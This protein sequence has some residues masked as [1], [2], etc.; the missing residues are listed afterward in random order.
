ML[1]DAE[2]VKKLQK[3]IDPHPG[4]P[5]KGI[6]PGFWHDQADRLGMP[7]DCPVVPLGVSGDRCWLLDSIGQVRFFDPPYG[8]GNMLGLFGGRIEYLTWAWPRWGK[9]KVINGFANEE[10][11]ATLIKACTL[12]GPWEPQDSERWQG[13]WTDAGGNL[14]VHTGDKVIQCD[15]KGGGQ[16]MAPG[17]QDGFVYPARTKI[18][19]PTSL[20]D[21]PP[22]NGAVVMRTELRKWN[23]VRPEID[24]HLLLGWIGGAFLGGAL[25]WRPMAFLT[26]DKATGKSTLQNMLKGLFGDWLVSAADTTAA[27]IYQRIGLSCRPVAIDELESEADVRK[28]KAV[29]KLARLAA[30]GDDFL[31]GGSEHRGV[32]FKARSSFLF[33]SINAPPLEPQDLSRMALLRLNRLTEGSKPPLI[34]PRLLHVVGRSILRQLIREWPRFQETFDAFAE[35]LAAGG[36]DGRGQAQYGTLLTCADMME[37]HGWDADRVRFALDVEGDLVPWRELLRPSQMHEYEDQTE[38]WKACLS[39]LLGTRVEA[40]RSGRRQTVGELLLAWHNRDETDSSQVNSEL[41]QAG[42]RIVSRAE[43]ELGGARSSCSSLSAGKR[44]WWLAVHNQGPLVR[45]LFDGSKWAGELGAGVWSAAL[46][47]G[48]RGTVWELGNAVRVNGVAQKT[49]LVSL[50]GLF[51]PGGV[52]AEDE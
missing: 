13:C 50:E 7:P 19:G 5:R 11:A 51:G 42:L 6:G 37:Y 49:T 28:Q 33:S 44:T 34:D 8:K 47:Q 38:N 40:W 27:G 31:R 2:P 25:A 26:G 22:F 18:H 41:A 35:E 16:V 52:M 17:E 12:L 39:H 14:V 20:K 15:A 48:P 9:E 43:G 36:M 32:K 21:D 29:L 1:A 30:S 4:E 45:Q 24:P 3:A 10:A 46:R 23:W